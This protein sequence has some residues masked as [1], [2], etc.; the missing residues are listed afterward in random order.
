M[1]PEAHLIFQAYGFP[2]LPF[3][4]GIQPRKRHWPPKSWIPVAAKIVS[5]TSSKNSN[6]GGVKLPL[7]SAGE[8]AQ[9][10]EEIMAG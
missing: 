7:H 6:V 9:A 10:Y 4:W 3:R 5:P 1:E 8:V 2:T